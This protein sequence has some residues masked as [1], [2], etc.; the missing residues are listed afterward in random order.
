MST[1]S[2]FRE[3]LARKRV[4]RVAVTLLPGDVFRQHALIR[5]YQNISN[6]GFFEQ[7]LPF[8]DTRPANE[9]GDIDVIFRVAKK[10]TGAE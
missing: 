6:L 5:S 8:P 9:Q 10:R 1:G 3:P 2:R 7:P 4:I